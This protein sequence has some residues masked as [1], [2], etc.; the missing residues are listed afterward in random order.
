MAMITRLRV[1]LLL[2]K[3]QTFLDNFLEEFPG[4]SGLL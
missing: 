4:A 1:V 3:M 2:V